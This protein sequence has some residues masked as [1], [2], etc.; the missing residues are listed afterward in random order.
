MPKKSESHNEN[1]GR[2]RM[3]GRARKAGREEGPGN[4]SDY[5]QQIREKKLAEGNKKKGCFPKLF[6]LVLPFIAVGTY[7]FLGS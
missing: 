3:Q 7:L 6:M 4:M 1:K 2:S 5:R